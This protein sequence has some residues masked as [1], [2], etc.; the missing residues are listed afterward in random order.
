M[1]ERIRRLAIALMLFVLPWQPLAI[2][3]PIATPDD[4]INLVN[5]AERRADKVGHSH[6]ERSHAFQISADNGSAPSGET[7]GE[8]PDACCFP[9]LPADD[10][11][12]AVVIQ[13]HGV[14][15]PFA[16]LPLR[17]RAPD[18]I[19]HPPRRLLA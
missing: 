18:A 9:A 15:I 11:S 13:D 19:D 3:M 17:W 6:H 14:V 16:V 7:Q 4:S 2:A 8:C 10:R 1:F 5:D 12:L